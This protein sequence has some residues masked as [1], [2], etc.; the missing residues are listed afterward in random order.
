MTNSD[1]EVEAVES[2]SI[3]FGHDKQRSLDLCEEHGE[4]ARLLRAAARS[5][6]HAE[7]LAELRHGRLAS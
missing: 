2:I 1:E 4:I 6:G 3:K 7:G 5:R